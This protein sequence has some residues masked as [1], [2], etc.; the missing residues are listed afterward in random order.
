L[1]V[2]SLIHGLALTLAAFVPFAVAA[3]APDIMVLHS[4]P[5][6]PAM[7]D[8]IVAFTKSSGHK[9]TAEH[10]TSGA[11]GMRIQ[12][13]EIVDMAVVT[14]PQ[15]R[16]LQKRGR[17]VEGSVIDI[18]KVG[19]GVYTRKGGPKRDISSL[20]AFK[21][22]LVDANSIGYLDPASGAVGGIYVAG[23]IERLNL[24]AE[25]KSKTKINMVAA[26]VVDSVANGTVEIGVGQMSEI[27]A[28]PRIE[29]VGP[30]PAEVQL[31]TLF[32]AGIA[33]V[34]TQPEIAKALVQFISFP[35]A[36][37][38]WTAKGFQLP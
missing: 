17:V 4:T 30:L 26:A 16:D 36:Q 33:T 20:E 12:N 10:G 35:A 27:A 21:R 14:G 37:A 38:I 22:A 25:L 15:I 3:T 23:L 7:D 31:F 32:T 28:D 5:V 24:T 11:T 13:G 29:L 2:R 8:L 1:T 9:V 34:S 19:L 18:A 6:K